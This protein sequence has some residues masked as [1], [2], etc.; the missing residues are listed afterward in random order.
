LH[1]VAYFV[2]TQQ[3]KKP[4]SPNDFVEILVRDRPIG[5][6]RQASTPVG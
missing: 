2:Y 3:H 4:A 6:R 5:R 1:A